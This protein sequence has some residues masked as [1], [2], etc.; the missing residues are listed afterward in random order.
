LWGSV[1]PWLS[2]AKPKP[3]HFLG[4]FDREE[5][6]HQDEWR[7]NEL[8]AKK[9]KHNFEGKNSASVIHLHFPLRNIVVWKIQRLNFGDQFPL[10]NIFFWLWI[11]FLNSYDNFF[12]K[13]SIIKYCIRNPNKLGQN[14]SNVRR[15]K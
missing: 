2:P 12:N 15:K 5:A 11:F 8:A 13:H 10:R 3:T 6:E 1:S 4:R 7:K 9:E 14:I